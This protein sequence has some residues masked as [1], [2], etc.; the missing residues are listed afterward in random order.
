MAKM[1]STFWDRIRNHPDSTVRRAAVA[2]NPS[3]SPQELKELA[4]VISRKEEMNKSAAIADLLASNPNTAEDTQLKLASDWDYRDLFRR[5]LQNRQTP[6][7]LLHHLANS[8]NSRDRAAVARHPEVPAALLDK[9]ST[10]CEQVRIAVARNPRTPPKALSRLARDP[11]V[12][13]RKVVAGNSAAPPEAV[14]ALLNDR[15]SGVRERAAQ[16]QRDAS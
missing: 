7:T 11:E 4:E 1:P 8:R 3:V 6:A 14:E 12:K 9:L 16:T 10:D 15:T 2:S 13:V 5:I